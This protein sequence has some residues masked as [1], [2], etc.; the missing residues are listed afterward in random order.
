M[1]YE[2][3]MSVCT[4]WAWFLCYLMWTITLHDPRVY[5]SGNEVMFMYDIW[6]V[7][8]PL[9]IF[10]HD[11]KYDAMYL[12]DVMSD[13][14]HGHAHGFWHECVYRH[15]LGIVYDIVS[16]MNMDTLCYMTWNGSV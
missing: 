13:I 4:V 2:W 14:W 5:D 7:W 10:G 8:L 12:Y 16:D 9:M 3:W 15:E 6:N 1:I 11:S